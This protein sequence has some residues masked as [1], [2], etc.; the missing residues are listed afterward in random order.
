MSIRQYKDSYLYNK[1]SIKVLELYNF[2]NSEPQ[3]NLET[4]V[5][6]ILGINN[7]ATVFFNYEG[8]TTFMFIMSKSGV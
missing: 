1:N 5:N 4:S 3:L 2:I 6:N 8:Y 7:I